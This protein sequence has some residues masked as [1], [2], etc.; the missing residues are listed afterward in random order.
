M[1]L[2][3][4]F[5][6][7]KLNKDDII[8]ILS[9][10]YGK[11]CPPELLKEFEEISQKHYLFRTYD[12]RW[13]F[14]IISTYQKLNKKKKIVTLLNYLTHEKLIS[15]RLTAVGENA[16]RFFDTWGKWD[17]YLMLEQNIIQYEI[18][19]ENS[20]SKLIYP[21][22]AFSNEEQLACMKNRYDIKYLSRTVHL[23]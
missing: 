1:S 10:E 14:Y 7:E 4:A 15:L 18:L 11:E 22:F 20:T 12:S 6:K 2:K 13:L 23:D 17:E 5:T 9:I 16:I 8:Y 3:C 21:R 19:D